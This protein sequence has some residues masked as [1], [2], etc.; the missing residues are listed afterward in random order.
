[1]LL[2]ILYEFIEVLPD[3]RLGYDDCCAVVD[4]C[5]GDEVVKCVSDILGDRENSVDTVV[6]EQD[7][8]SVRK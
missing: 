5:N 2:C 8:V 1:M 7:S 6:S 4:S 3:T